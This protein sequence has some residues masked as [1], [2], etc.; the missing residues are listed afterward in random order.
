MLTLTRLD[1][2][3]RATGD[4]RLPRFTGSA[5]RGAFGKSL[6]QHVCLTGAP[7]CSGCPVSDRCAYHA[8]F[9]PAPSAD[10]PLLQGY[11]D[12]PRPYLL[13]TAAGG[14][15][16]AGEEHR[17]AIVLT[18]TADRARA[19]V[20]AAMRNAVSR[21]H[22]A[23]R[24][25]AAQWQVAPCPTPPA[26]P[27]SVLIH[28]LSPLRIRVQG[29]YLGADSFHLPAFVSSLLRRCSQMLALY[30]GERPPEVDARALI[31]HAASLQLSE[32]S[33]QDVALARYSSR[34]KQ[35][36]P[37]DGVIGRLHLRGELEPLWPWLWLG[38]YLHVGKGADMGLGQYRLQCDD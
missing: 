27:Q 33:L 29:R 14:E 37:L 9:E 20:E 10:T 35:R 28:L 11:P 13:Q 18:G 15:V 38:Q 22:P 23:L 21:V 6:R 32:C 5:W 25:E 31:D 34:Q 24:L 4:L 19:A 30:G 8:I 36:I 7:E 1:L 17:A 12:A 3:C 26:A 16:A 2:S